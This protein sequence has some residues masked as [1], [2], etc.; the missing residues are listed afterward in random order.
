MKEFQRIDEYEKDELFFENSKSGLNIGILFVAYVIIAFSL[1][2]L[3]PKIYLTNNIYYASR[4]IAKLQTQKDL[5]T[6]END[7]LKR[8]LEKIKFKYL[9]MNLD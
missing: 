8:E 3:V 6:E 9:M 2:I 4:D 1:I 5:L 7:R